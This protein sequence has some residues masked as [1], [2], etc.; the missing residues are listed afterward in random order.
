M[1]RKKKKNGLKIPHRRN[2]ASA[3]QKEERKSSVSG[4]VELGLARR[5]LSE[6]RRRIYLPVATSSLYS[7]YRGLWSAELASLLPLSPPPIRKTVHNR[8]YFEFIRLS[9]PP[10]G[11]RAHNC[12]E[13][14]DIEA[15]TSTETGSTWHTGLVGFRSGEI[16]TCANRRVGEIILDDNSRIRGGDAKRKDAHRR[17]S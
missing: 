6:P 10:A 12:I 4:N 1:L 2:C 8:G 17:I 15:A 9:P 3:L 7:H 16:C 13:P 14:A 11:A 5:K